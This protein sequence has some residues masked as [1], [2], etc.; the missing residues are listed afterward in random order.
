[1]KRTFT[2]YSHLHLIG[3]NQGT[4]YMYTGLNVKEQIIQFG[5]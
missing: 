5:Q 3:V 4:I 1:M 2:L